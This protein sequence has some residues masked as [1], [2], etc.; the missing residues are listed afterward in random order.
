MMSLFSRS[1]LRL[2]QLVEGL[3]LS[4][5]CT[6]TVIKGISLDS[7]ALMPGGLFIA[8]KGSELDGTKFV[9]EAIKRGAVAVLLETD[10]QNLGGTIEIIKAAIPIIGVENLS[11]NVSA[12]ASRFYGDPS[13]RLGIAGVTGTNGKTTCCQLYADLLSQLKENHSGS[14][15]TNSCGY[16]GTLGHGFIS[17]T[18]AICDDEPAENRVMDKA[19]LTTPDAIT[20]QRLLDELEKTGCSDVAIEVSSHSLVQNRISAVKI[21]TAIFT[22]LSRDHLDYHGDLDSYAAAKASL[23]KMPGLKNAVIN[24]DD[25]LGKTILADLDPS[26]RSLSFSLENITADIHC[27]SIDLCPD[28]L[29]AVIQTPWGSGKI[30]SPLL[31]KF[32]LSNLL[33]VIGAVALHEGDLGHTNFQQILTLVPKLK[34]VPG[35]MELV[36]DSADFA[37]IVDY[38]H[39]PDALEKALQALRLHCEGSLWVVF[40]CGGD[41]DTG[42]RPEMGAV[43]FKY[44]DRVIV[45]SDNPRTESPDQIIDHIVKGIKGQCCIESDRRAAI[46]KAVLGAEPGDVILIAGKG[47]ENYQILG[48]QRVAFSDQAEA[49]LALHQRSP[50][51]KLGGES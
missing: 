31:G 25:D 22:N 2:P 47:H 1:A 45:T 20:M 33:A 43:A 17:D 48:V 46:N 41:R 28:G 13:E 27:Q 37:V 29:N 35:R 40:G 32:N 15:T 24:I 3:S 30:K 44:A 12:I 34:S 7:R 51:Q 23:F 4:K 38:A 21:D 14:V 18:D 19:P 9:P 42:K 16:I 6:S 8:L 36:S 39:T 5:K 49:R 50:L 26:I 11:Q 10:R